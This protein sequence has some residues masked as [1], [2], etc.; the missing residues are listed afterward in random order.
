MGVDDT[1]S[2]GG[3]RALALKLSDLSPD[4]VLFLRAPVV[5]VGR[6]GG[7]PVMRLDLARAPELWNAVRQGTAGAYVQQNARDALGPVTR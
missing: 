6:D 4:D 1:L 3:M 5:A 2:N 7:G